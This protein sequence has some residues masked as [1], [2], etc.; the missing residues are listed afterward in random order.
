M[1][2]TSHIAGLLVCLALAGCGSS[3]ARLLAESP[4]LGVQ[5]QS[6]RD[7]QNLPPPA[8]KLYVALFAFQDQTGQH[9]PNDSYADYSLA[10]TQGGAAILVNALRDAGRQKWF[11][12]LERNRLGDLFQERQII[13]ANRAENLGPGGK[14]LPP[15]GPLLNAGVLLEGGIVGYDSSLLT[16][17]IGAN[18]LGIGGTAQYRK[19]SVAIY[20]RAISV[21]TG[22]VLVAVTTD[23]TIYSAGVSGLVNKYV[24]FNQLLQAEA[25]VTTNEPVQ[26]AVRQAIEKAVYAL[27]VE[28]AEKGI[29]NFADKA[30]QQELVAAYVAERDG[31]VMVT[32]AP[33]SAQPAAQQSPPM[34]RPAAPPPAAPTEGPP[35]SS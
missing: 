14:P 13:R 31:T 20:L 26:L 4:S 17:G 30:R 25:G 7:L 34:T 6:S 1:S 12:V 24:S 3:A 10:V 27:V 35:A 18:F 19:D 28:G 8:D 2:Y 33:A 15:L 5:T 22:E 23:K 16:G 9:K 11:S 21:L 32:P 29:W